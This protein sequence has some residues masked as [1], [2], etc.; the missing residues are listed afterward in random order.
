MDE[1]DTAARLKTLASADKR[2]AEAADD[3]KAAF[4]AEVLAADDLGWS[5]AA[6]ATA[7]GRSA[8]TVQSIIS[9]R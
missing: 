2:A 9:R 6:I 1:N 8:S 3:A 5:T 7:A 4:H